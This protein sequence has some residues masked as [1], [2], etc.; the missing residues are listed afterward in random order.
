MEQKVLAVI[1]ARSGSK[2]VPHKNIRKINGKPMLAYSIGHAMASD[3]VNRILLSTDSEEYAGIGREFGAETP[4]L[5]PACYATDTATD[6]DVFYHCMTWL[7]E[8]EGYVPDVV[9]QLRPTYPIR[10]PKDIDRMVELLLR[11]PE[12][13][14]VR[15]I[16]PAKEIAYKMWRKNEDGTIR[17]ILTDIREAYNMPRQELPAIYYQN[18][19]IDVTRGSVILEKHSMTGDK[20]L[21]YEMAHNFDIDTEAEWT[22]ARA[23]LELTEG[24]RRLV[25]DI[26]GVVA[27]LRPDLDYAEAEP[28][29][30]MVRLINRLYE[31][32]NHI[33][34]FTARGYVTGK[35]WERV[36]RKQFERWGLKYHELIFGKP[37]ADFY[38]DD[39]MLDMDLLK[40]FLL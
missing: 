16:A 39:K 30:D 10:D 40:N 31:A 6:L 2:S 18:A 35:D 32:G 17:P 7:K 4:F 22:A 38:V 9:V 33:V 15:S 34:M 5:R 19:C 25:F 37:N 11:H 8:Q 12:A 23:C 21:G 27:K 13:D 1:P 36:T 20:I 3:R 28:E 24:N 26:D 14:S 29:E